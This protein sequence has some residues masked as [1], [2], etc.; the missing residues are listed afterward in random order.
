MKL[1]ELARDVKTDKVKSALN[2][3]DTDDL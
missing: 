1:L 3:Q 2:F